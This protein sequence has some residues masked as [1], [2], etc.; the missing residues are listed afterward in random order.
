MGRPLRFL[1]LD[2]HEGES[3]VRPTV[4]VLKSCRTE[5]FYFGTFGDFYAAI[6]SSTKR[7]IDD[8][9]GASC[10]ANQPLGQLVRFLPG[11]GTRPLSAIRRIDLLVAKLLDEQ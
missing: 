9:T 11:M 2:E 1:P 7:V 8:I 10:M 4:R 5:E 6:D 3:P